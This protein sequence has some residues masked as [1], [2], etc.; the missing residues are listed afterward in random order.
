MAVLL[1][2]ALQLLVQLARVRRREQVD[3]LVHLDS[4]TSYLMIYLQIYL[5]ST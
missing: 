5:V 1:A 2:R 4:Y 3:E